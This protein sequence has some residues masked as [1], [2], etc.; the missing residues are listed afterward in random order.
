MLAPRSRNSLKW[1]GNH[2]PTF[3]L[4]LHPDQ[5]IHHE[6]HQAEAESHFTEV[7]LPEMANRLDSVGDAGY[8]AAD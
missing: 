4:R 5:H 3:A 8:D 7:V 2:V 1:L 6:A